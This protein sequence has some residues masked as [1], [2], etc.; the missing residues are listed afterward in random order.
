MSTKGEVLQGDISEVSG[1]TRRRS[2]ELINANM[3]SRLG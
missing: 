2:S 3:V 1:P